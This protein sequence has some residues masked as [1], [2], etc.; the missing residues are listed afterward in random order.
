MAGTASRKGRLLTAVPLPEKIRVAT[1]IPG[2]LFPDQ[3][4]GVLL[5]QM[6]KLGQK[7]RVVVIRL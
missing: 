6:R 1:L 3:K 5:E 4:D 7:T 2:N